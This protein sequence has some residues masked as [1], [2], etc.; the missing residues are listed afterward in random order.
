MEIQQ[1]VEAQRVYYESG[2]TQPLQ[3]R[4]QAL[5]RLLDGLGRYEERILA[6]LQQDLGKAPFEGYMT[7]LGM[8]RDELRW[9]RSHLKRCARDRRAVTPLAQFKA[10]SFISPHP[11]GLVL[12]MAPWNYPLQLSLE[13]LIGAVAAG[14]CAVLK[15]SDY[16]PQTAQ[17]MA[18]LL[19][20]CFDSRHVAVVLGGRKQNQA[21]LDQRFDRIFF[22]GGARVGRLVLEKAAAHLTPVTLELGGKSPC[23][24]TDSANLQLAARRIVFGKFLNAGQTCVAPDYLLVQRGAQPRLLEL[25]GG[26]ITQAFG[27]EPLQCQEYP[28]IVNQKHFTRL[29]GL[30]EG[31][32]KAIGGRCDPDALRIE[33][34]VLTDVSPAAP[35]MQE[36]IF[37]PLLPMLVYDKLEE[38]IA[39]VAAREHPLA[40]YLFT[41]K[42]AEEHQVL[43]SLQFGG[44][45]INDTIIH[46][47]TSRMPFGGVG[48]SGMG[49]YH[50]K[51]SFDTFT[52]YRSI[53]KK[54]NR[55][56]LPVRYHPYDEK[57]F[58]LLRRFFR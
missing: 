56:D 4:A 1:I 8:V 57:K 33:P 23:I 31:C 28:R 19:G 12:V 7:E 6:A 27:A 3:A 52:H 39:F 30:M 37:G 9:Q 47:A 41:E 34:T 36:E 55:I 5:D 49:S 20:E 40:L 53:V 45:C 58:A 43:G 54:S 38:A 51:Q 11:Y 29:Q 14:N 22:T 10:K 44:G 50:G 18:A 21:L 2:A 46:L 26:E 15:P 16:A 17:V 48:R 35:L 25:L 32:Q 13:P 24:V 42:K